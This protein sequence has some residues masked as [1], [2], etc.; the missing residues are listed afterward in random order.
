MR[1]KFLWLLKRVAVLFTATLFFFT[2]GFSQNY[3]GEYELYNLPG[4]IFFNTF[5]ENIAPETILLIEESNGF[6]FLDSPSV[7]FQGESVRDFLWSIDDFSNTSNLYPGKWLVYLPLSLQKSFEVIEESPEEFISGAVLKTGIKEQIL[8]SSVISQIGDNVS[9]RK[10]VLSPHPD[11]RNKYLWDER[12]RFRNNFIFD[13]SKILL[14]GK[15]KDYFAFNYF[16][17]ERFFNDFSRKNEV[18]SENVKGFSFSNFLLAEDFKFFTALNYIERGKYLSEFRRLP[19]ETLRLYL[20]SFLTGLN[21]KGFKLQVS[22]ERENRNTQRDV[23]FKDLFD[24]DGEGIKFNE[25]IGKFEVFSA[26]IYYRKGFEFKGFDTKIYTGIKFLSYKGKPSF[27]K[28]I[29][30]EYKGD[31]YEKV[32]PFSEGKFTNGRKDFFIQFISKK[33]AFNEKIELLFKCGVYYSLL[34]FS[35]SERDSSFFNYTFLSGFK[36]RASK[37]FKL[38]VYAGR[39]RNRIPY[40]F[41]LLFE[42]KME[43]LSVYSSN[44]EFKGFSGFGSWEISESIKSPYENYINLGAEYRFFNGFRIGVKALSKVFKNRFWL[45]YRGGQL[46]EAS[47]GFSI[48]TLPVEGYVLS[49]YRFK[50]L[51]FYKEFLIYM[52][53]RKKGFYSFGFSF[54]AHIGMGYT[55]F[56]N[57]IENDIGYLSEE[58][59]DPNTWI[60]GFGRVD[61]D[62]AFVGKIFYVRR[63]F[64][65]LNFGFTFKYR[66]G[67]PF[68]YILYKKVNGQ[69]IYYYKTII[70]ENRYGVK[71]GPREDYM[72]DFSLKLSYDFKKGKKTYSISFELFNVLDIGAELSENVFDDGGRYSIEKQL[73]RSGRI[74]LRIL[75]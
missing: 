19:D 18:Y 74:T 45:N 1:I 52:R 65:G 17:G 46:R 37:N 25:R 61:G 69:L 51:P 56:G 29:F 23:L 10:T 33:V 49:S 22:L 40:D 75:F 68:A 43:K 20:F 4:G 62:R 60:N 12:R 9:F 8:L 67:D 26:E 66:D 59:A 11:E 72:A 7:Y 24:I 6:S 15:I 5:F 41:N 50:D 70:A 2:I 57:G 48:L 31:V 42:S 21:F 30:Y 34:N 47:D 54:M 13:L 36:Y 3:L 55:S 71:G 35:G 32:V 28:S 64:K 53:K 58:M 39:I 73:P 27:F 44:G 16:S 14:N 38:Y 63:L